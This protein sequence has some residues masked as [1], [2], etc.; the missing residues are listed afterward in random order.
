VLP[1]SATDELAAFFARVFLPQHE[2]ATVA[3]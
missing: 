3:G 1:L 2:P